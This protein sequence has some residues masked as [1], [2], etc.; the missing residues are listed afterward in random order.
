MTYS[1][2]TLS[3]NCKT[4]L[5][6]ESSVILEGIMQHNLQK[7]YPGEILDRVKHDENMSSEGDIAMADVIIGPPQRAVSLAVWQPRHFVEGSVRALMP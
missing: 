7:A 5:R 4:S 1:F 6:F 3:S 2:P